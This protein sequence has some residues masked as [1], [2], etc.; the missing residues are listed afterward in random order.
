MFVKVYKIALGLLLLC[1]WVAAMPVSYIGARGG[2]GVADPPR[3]FVR[4]G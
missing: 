1:T 3:L 4:G 2:D